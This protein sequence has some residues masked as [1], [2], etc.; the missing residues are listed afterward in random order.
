MTWVHD[1]DVDGDVE[2]GAGIGSEV[3]REGLDRAGVCVAAGAPR[4]GRGRGVRV[5]RI[6]HRAA[7]AA[8]VSHPDQGGSSHQEGW[9]RKGSIT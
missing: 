6:R 2:P 5:W 3:V 7:A 1:E 9:K 8:S 4:Q